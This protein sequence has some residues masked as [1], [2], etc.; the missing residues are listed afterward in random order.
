MAIK[1]IEEQLTF[2]EKDTLDDANDVDMSVYRFER[3][4]DSRNKYIFV[5]RQR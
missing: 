5:K 2:L 1:T 4:S 3:F